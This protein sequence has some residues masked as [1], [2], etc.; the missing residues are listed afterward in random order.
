M[1]LSSSASMNMSG[2]W[3][4]AS[5]TPGIAGFSIGDAIA[6]AADTRSSSSA[7]RPA[8][9]PPKLC[10]NTPMYSNA[11]VMVPSGNRLLSWSIRNRMSAARTSSSSE[12]NGPSLPAR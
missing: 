9:T 3:M 10:P 11:V 7:T 4:F 1:L 8:V 2:M 12:V 5:V 6:T